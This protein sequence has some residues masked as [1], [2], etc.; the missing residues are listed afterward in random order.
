MI[1][2]EALQRP[3]T[4]AEFGWGA[5]L[6]AVWFFLPHFDLRGDI[7]KRGGL[8]APPVV[9]YLAQLQGYL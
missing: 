4:G 9:T 8:G 2:L 1:S 6:S 5:W 7:I 3:Q